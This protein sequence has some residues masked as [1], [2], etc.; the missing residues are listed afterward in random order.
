[1]DFLSLGQTALAAKQYRIQ[2]K[3]RTKQ[4]E[5]EELKIQAQPYQYRSIT[6]KQLQVLIF[7]RFHKRTKSRA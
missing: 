4:K 6:K 3:L 5:M 7:Y 1:M 2:Q